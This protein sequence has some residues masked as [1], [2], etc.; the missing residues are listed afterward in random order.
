MTLA[1]VSNG[2][3]APQ[4]H[5]FGAMLDHMPQ[6]TILCECN[7]RLL[8]ANSS[9]LSILEA[10]D[11]LLLTRG[12]ITA[13]DG[14]AGPL[15]AA[16]KQACHESKPEVASMFV[17]RADG[18]P[19]IISVTPVPQATE[20]RCALLLVQKLSQPGDGVAAQLRHLFKLSPAEALIAIRIAGGSSINEIAEERGVSIS[21]VQA[22]RKS[23]A[24]K[25]GCRRQAEIGG[26]VASL[27]AAVA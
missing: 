12:V 19:L 26:L 1:N 27:S 25:L 13:G 16:I 24:A 8:Y 14:D 15:R 3:P 9:A 11:G 7:G 10:A 20:T 17:Q 22:Q 18:T 23:L 6:G 4:A 2:S 5:T 21:T